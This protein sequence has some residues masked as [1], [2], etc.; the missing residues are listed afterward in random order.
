MR[1]MVNACLMLIM[2]LLTLTGWNHASSIQVAEAAAP[3]QLFS[4]DFESGNLGKWTSCF[5]G[6]NSVTTE[7]THSGSYSL[8]S[9]LQVFGP[10]EIQPSPQPTQTRIYISFWVNWG[11][12]YGCYNHWWR[13]FTPDGSQLDFERNFSPCKGGATP[14]FNVAFLFNFTSGNAPTW[15][16]LDPFWN[17]SDNA[18]HQIEMLIH[19]NTPGL[20]DGLVKVWIDRILVLDSN[21]GAG[22][23]AG[24]PKMPRD[25]NTTGFTKL[26]IVSNFDVIGQFDCNTTGGVQPC[27]DPSLDYFMYIDDVEWWTDCPVSGASCSI[28]PSPPQRFRVR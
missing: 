26:V 1:R 5:A 10:C 22:I 25:T 11:N 7:K 27:T 23:R 2:V 24:N 12:T 16:I 13:L 28:R 20:A 19:L 15:G 18:W 4:D 9:N 6:A 14:T 8:K 3:T 17:N 21:S